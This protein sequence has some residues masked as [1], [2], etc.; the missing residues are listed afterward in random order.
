[1][2]HH[3]TVLDR[4]TGPWT[5]GIDVSAY[6]PDIDWPATAGSHV[7]VKRRETGETIR[8]LGEPLYA[9]VR[10]ADGIQT[11]HGS[12][13]DPWAVRHLT[14]AHEAGLLVAGYHYFRA[15]HDG[16]EQAEIAL[17]AVRV[18]GVPVPWIGLDFETKGMTWAPAGEAAPSVERGLEQGARF[19]RRILAAGIRPVV[20]SGVWWHEQVAQKRRQAPRVLREADLW[21]AWYTAG[22]RYALPVT[23]DGGPWPW[24]QADIWQ[25]GGGG[26]GIEGRCGGIYG[27]IDAN[28]FRGDAEALRAWWGGRYTVPEQA[29]DPIAES[30]DAATRPTDPA[31]E[32]L[33]AEAVRELEAMAARFKAADDQGAVAELLRCASKLAG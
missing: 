1:M 33:R 29:R 32:T 27:P 30:R 22:E 4:Y 15:F 10:L 12:D 20:Y 17:E 26:A 2:T 6:Q 25:A 18:A 31:P 7:L 24:A 8:D 9:I 11:R 19:A 3:R 16:E 14:G 23:P 5:A 21:T 13:V 28:R